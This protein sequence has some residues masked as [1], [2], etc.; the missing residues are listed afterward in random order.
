MNPAMSDSLRAT[1]NYGF[2]IKG[3]DEGNITLESIER[4]GSTYKLRGVQKPER[5]IQ[6]DL[7]EFQLEQLIKK[8]PKYSTF[9]RRGE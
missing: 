3:I 6:A 1:V 2:I 7:S 4:A 5:G 8:H 9:V